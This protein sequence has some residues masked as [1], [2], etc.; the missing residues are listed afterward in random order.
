M[1]VSPT[2]GLEEEAREAVRRQAAMEA[3]L[4]EAPAEPVPQG[5]EAPLGE[6]DQRSSVPEAVAMPAEEAS[7]QVLPFGLAGTRA[8]ASRKSADAGPDAGQGPEP[9]AAPGKAPGQPQGPPA[10]AGP[11]TELDALLGKLTSDTPGE[12]KK[13]PG[14]PGA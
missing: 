1:G 7:N 6:E 5:S 2:A 13:G 4:P 9:G 12:G 11:E 8:P 14:K 10:A 3:T